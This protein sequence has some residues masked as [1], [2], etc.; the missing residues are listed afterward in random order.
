[1]TEERSQVSLITAPPKVTSFVL[2]CFVFRL[3][4]CKVFF[5][6]LKYLSIQ[7]FSGNFL[8]VAVSSLMWPRCNQVKSKNLHFEGFFL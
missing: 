4:A 5:S 7:I 1:M 3:N 6:V 2:F 8:S